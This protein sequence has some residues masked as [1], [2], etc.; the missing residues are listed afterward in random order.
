MVPLL[1]T[2]AR[3]FVKKRGRMTGIV[4][5][6]VGTGTVII[7]L[8]ATWLVN[9]YGWRTSFLAIAVLSAFFTIL[10]AQ[11]LR[12]DPQ[13]SG[14]LPDGDT[15]TT[16]ETSIKDESGFSFRGAIRT[17]QIWMLSATYFCLG[18]S[19]FA[20]I[21]HIVI[22]AI[23]QGLSSGSAATVLAISGG[24]N[25]GARAAMGSVSDKIGNRPVLIIGIVTM[26]AALA[27]LQFANES[28]MLYLFGAVFGLAYGSTIVTE[29]PIVAEF[30]GLRTHGVLFGIVDVG[31]TTGGTLGPVLIGYI[32]DVTGSYQ[33]GFLILAVMSLIGLILA[34][35]LRPIRKVS[36]LGTA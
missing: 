3:W 27:W 2:T 11:Y 33:L 21:V 15:K 29:S 1:S 34:L 19:I 8:M 31:F 25:I 23:G 5:A 18:F 22:H 9:N 6:G 12:R 30:F 20:I 7:P 14:L 28:W 26:V 17:K 24:L 35:S 10:S 16:N 36:V 32:F 13:S 4:L